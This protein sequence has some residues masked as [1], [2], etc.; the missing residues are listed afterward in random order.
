MG[1]GSSLQFA[2][3]CQEC[4]E[5]RT[6]R[7]R[8]LETRTR[9]PAPAFAGEI[10]AIYGAV[11][12]TTLAVILPVTM[13]PVD[14]TFPML[15]S[16]VTVAVIRASPQASPVAVIRPVAASTVIRSGVFDFQATWSVMSLLTGGCM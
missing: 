16:V 7:R 8:I 10:A 9:N 4:A 13:A 11:K 5:G 6:E 12:Q 15:W 2:A 3:G 1:S 14:D